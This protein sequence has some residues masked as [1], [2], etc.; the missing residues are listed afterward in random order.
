M[1]IEIK[2]NNAYVYTPYHPGFVREIKTIGRDR[3]DPLEKCWT[4]PAACR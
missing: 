2:D 1:K 4:V 3:W